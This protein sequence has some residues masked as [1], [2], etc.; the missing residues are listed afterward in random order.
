MGTHP[1]PTRRFYASNV[2]SA[3]IMKSDATALS[4]QRKYDIENH[5]HGQHASM[6]VDI[7]LQTHLPLPAISTVDELLRGHEVTKNDVTLLKL[8][9]LA[10]PYGRTRKAATSDRTRGSP[11]RCVHVAS[12]RPLARLA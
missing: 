1:Y 10:P 7:C 9:A 8:G 2:T 12:R 6:W 4:A 11:M 5:R 3:Q